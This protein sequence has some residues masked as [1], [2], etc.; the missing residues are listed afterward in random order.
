MRQNSPHLV[1]NNLAGFLELLLLAPLGTVEERP[2]DAVVLLDDFIYTVALVQAPRPP[3]RRS[4]ATTRTLP[5]PRR[6][7]DCLRGPS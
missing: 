5:N 2:N 4:A 3:A 1:V 6:S 7:Y